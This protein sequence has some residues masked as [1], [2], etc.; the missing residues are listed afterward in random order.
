MIFPKE[1]RKEKWVELM[2]KGFNQ[3]FITEEELGLCLKSECMPVELIET[4]QAR[5]DLS[6]ITWELLKRQ[7]EGE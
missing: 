7:L 3:G 4:I 6:T 2:N 5:I 1:S